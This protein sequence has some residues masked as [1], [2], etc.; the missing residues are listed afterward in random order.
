V[1][2]LINKVN[3]LKENGL[4]GVCMVAHWLAQGV[5]PLKKQVHPSW[6]YSGL[7][8]PTQETQEKMAPELLVKH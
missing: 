8:D 2:A 3:L 5:Q 4:I 1:A 7:Q 6:E